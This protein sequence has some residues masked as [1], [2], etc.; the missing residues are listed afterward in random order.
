MK[1]VQVAEKLI[2]EAV[3]AIAR[4]E[5]VTTNRSNSESY[6]VGPVI[7]GL[8]MVIQDDR[9]IDHWV[10]SRLDMAKRWFIDGHDH[11]NLYV[12]GVL[13]VSATAVTV[14][15]L[16]RFK[17]DDEEQAARDREKMEVDGEG[18]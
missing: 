11:E 12:R 6:I 15:L 9:G 4:I 8:V 2:I 5:V 10:T 7:V 18:E 3:T 14:A 17:K 13:A 1:E 16:A